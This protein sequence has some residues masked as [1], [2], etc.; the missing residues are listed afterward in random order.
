MND[1]ILRKNR[2]SLVC[3]IKIEGKHK[4][5]SFESP[6][7]LS[8]VLQREMVI[9]VGKPRAENEETENLEVSQDSIDEVITLDP[10]SAFP[11]PLTWFVNNCCMYLK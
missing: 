1:M 3:N 6:L 10:Q 4:I 2:L 7:V 8:N 5:V 9:G 11:V